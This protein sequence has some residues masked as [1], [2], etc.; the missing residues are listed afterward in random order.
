MTRKLVFWTA[1]NSYRSTKVMR[2]LP[3]GSPHPVTTL[4]WTENRI[5]Y[6]GMFNLRS[7]LKQTYDD[8]V[9]IVL[10]DPELRSMTEPLMP[11]ID[12]RIIYCY[13]DA[14]GLAI[15]KQFDEIALTL[16][17]SDDMYSNSAG[18]IIMNP[19]NK[20]WMTF[21]HGYAYDYYKA[22]LYL[23]DT[24]CTGPFYSRRLN[25]KSF[26]LFQREKRHPGHKS[27]ALYHPQELPAG[28]FCVTLHGNNTS[29]HLNMRNVLKGSRPDR[30]LFNMNFN[31]LMD[32]V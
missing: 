20:E 15:I 28:N 16:I 29:S 3:P 13:E 5:K 11:K 21:R 2:F 30:E 25:P 26:N 9:Y 31:N 12:D 14:P 24:I 8:F 10:M 23:Y 27:V 4:E 7:I 19:D 18:E 17:D 22:Q 1:F 32:I 6:F